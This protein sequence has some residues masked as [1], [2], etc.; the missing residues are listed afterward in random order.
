ML[1]LDSI[2]CSETN[3]CIFSHFKVYFYYQ[4]VIS[5]ILILLPEKSIGNEYGDYFDLCVFC[6]FKL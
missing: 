1:L 4:I 3:I 6:L 2:Q 5:Q